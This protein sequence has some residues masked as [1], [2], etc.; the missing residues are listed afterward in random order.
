MKPHCKSLACYYF[1]KLTNNSW[2][3]N[4]RN[5]H[6]IS[7]LKLEE[8]NGTFQMF[9]STSILKYFLIQV[10]WKM[11]FRNTFKYATSDFTVISKSSSIKKLLD[12]E[13]KIRL[14]LLFVETP[15]DHIAH[16]V[17]LCHLNTYSYNTSTSQQ[18]QRSIQCEHT[19]ACAL[20]SDICYNIYSRF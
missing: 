9:Q 10:L 2:T 13:I 11:R 1:L 3:R 7:T 8:S 15:S 6:W 16:Q 20:K 5:Y 4:K 14:L 17:T 12:L 19:T 18:L